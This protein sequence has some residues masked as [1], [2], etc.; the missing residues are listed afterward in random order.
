MLLAAAADRLEADVFTN[1]QPVADTSLFESDPNNNLGA[2]TNVPVGTTAVG[3]RSRGVIRFDLTVIPTNATVVSASMTIQ[4]VKRPA[5]GAASSVGLNRLLVPWGEGHGNGQIGQPAASG[6]ASWTNRMSPLVPWATPGGAVGTDFVAQ[7]SGSI[8]GVDQLGTY[9]FAST[10]G[11]VSDAQMWI[12]NPST[13]FGWMLLCQNEGTSA[14]A[15]RFGSRESASPPVLTLQYSLTTIPPPPSLSIP[16]L[17]GNQIQFSFDA[18]ANATYVVEARSALDGSAWA[19]L[20]NI[21]S[22]PNPATIFVSAPVT[23]ANRFCRVR[24]P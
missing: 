15:R 19:T 9:V 23:N 20:T 21:P 10:N 8:P 14:T 5:T 16:V 3:K 22:L 6:E 1:L 24:S 4:L 13:N 12:S 7:A 17:Q 11:L 18:Q 2:F